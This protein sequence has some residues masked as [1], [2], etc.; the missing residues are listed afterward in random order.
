MFFN[1]SYNLLYTYIYTRVTVGYIQFRTITLLMNF[2]QKL[3]INILYVSVWI[4]SFMVG[5]FFEFLSL[6]YR[7]QRDSVIMLYRFATPKIY[8]ISLY[9]YKDLLLLDE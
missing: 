8:S 3:F 7:K 9:S 2:V 4:I 1:K 5:V 6:R